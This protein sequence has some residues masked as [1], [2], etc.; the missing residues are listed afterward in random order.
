MAFTIKKNKSASPP[1]Q[2]LGC[3]VWET[4]LACNMKC[5]HCG[6]SAGKARPDEL[7]TGEC[8][9][10][11]EDLAQL[12]CGTV[13][14]MGGEPLVREDW[15]TIAGCVKDLNMDLSIVSN[16]LLME[17]Y[18]D[19]IS[20]LEPKVVGISL[21]GLEK[22]HDSIRRKGSFKTAMNAIK[23]LRD[24]DIQVTVISTVSTKNFNDLIK[25]KDLIIKKA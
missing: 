13:A 15:V 2:K 11:V 21:D 12:G 1:D 8:I 24:A 3:A 4:T 17:K 23:L 7:D 18:M 9:K 16:G 14:L 19:R 10:L 25:M 5:T 20:S 22:T 6:S